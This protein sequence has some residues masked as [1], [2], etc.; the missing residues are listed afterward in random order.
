M[1]P[2][3]GT[4]LGAAAIVASPALWAGLVEGTMPVDVSLTRYLVAVA[5]CWALLSLLVELAL[6]HEDDVARAVAERE[7]GER[8][9]R[10]EPGADVAAPAGTPEGSSAAGRSA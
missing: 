7:R 3:S 4:V 5:A 2:L 8:E 1:S 10:A 6:P 9:A